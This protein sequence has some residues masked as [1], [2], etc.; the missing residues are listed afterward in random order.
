MSKIIITLF[1][2]YVK[3]VSVRVSI[4]AHIF[5]VVLALA[6]FCLHLTGRRGNH[7]VIIVYQKESKR[8]DLSLTKRLPWSLL[9]CTMCKMKL[10]AGS[11]DCHTS[12][13]GHWFAM[14]SVGLGRGI[15]GVSC[16][17]HWRADDIRPYA[18]AAPVSSKLKTQ[19]NAD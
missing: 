18:P 10:A 1:W 16:V 2:T 13:V 9:I 17:L 11:T 12:D 8:I 14:T 5:Y 15:S 19:V 4:V 7:M 6:Q 3:I